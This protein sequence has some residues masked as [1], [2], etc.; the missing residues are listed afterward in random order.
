MQI[1]SSGYIK[2]FY[3]QD[4]QLFNAKSEGNSEIDINKMTINVLGASSKYIYSPYE[5]VSD[6]DELTDKDE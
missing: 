6:N 1:Y 3:G 4:Q 2:K 5:Y